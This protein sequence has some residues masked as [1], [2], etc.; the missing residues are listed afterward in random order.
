M[1]WGPCKVSCFG[2]TKSLD[3]FKDVSSVEGERKVQHLYHGI[4]WKGNLR[5]YS[6]TTSCITVIP[7]NALELKNF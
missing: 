7:P 5:P 1:L 4:L 3:E 2:A 6:V